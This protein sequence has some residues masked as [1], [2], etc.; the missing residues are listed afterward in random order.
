MLNR[1]AF[2]AAGAGLLIGL[3]RP[4]LF[5]QSSRT[6]IA[7][8][9]SKTCGCCAKWVD[10][11][12]ANG[13]QPTVHDEEEM[14]QLKNRLGIPSEVRSCHT[15]VLGN[16]LIEGHVPVREVRRLLEEQPKVAGLA[17]PGMPSLSPGMA[18]PGAQVGGFE[19]IA[20]QFDGS[21]RSFASY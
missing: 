18:P 8:Y 4:G 15:A 19:V 5:A 16:Y 9:K 17:V 20:F 21:T 1:R 3:R 10:Y 12:K 14:D 7:I 6:P 11:V 2:V 13:F